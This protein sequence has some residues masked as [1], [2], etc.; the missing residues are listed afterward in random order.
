MNISKEFT[1]VTP[2]SKALALTLF[3]VLPII[4]FW[5]GISYQ[6]IIQSTKDTNP[7][8][9]SPTEEPVACTLEA[10]MCPDGT[11][12]GRIAPDCEFEQCPEIKT[13]TNTFTGTI[14]AINYQCHMDGVCSVQI[15]KGSVVLEKGESLNKQEL[16]GTFP[17]DILDETKSNAYI[18]KQVE[19]YAGTVGGRTDSYTLFGSRSYYIKLI[20]DVQT[21]CGGIAGRLCPSGYFCKYNGTYPDASGTCIKTTG[22]KTTYTCPTTEYVDCIPGPD[23]AAKTDCSSAFLKWAQSNCPN[24]KGAAY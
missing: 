19:V 7:I 14:T 23:K 13:I 5:L 11:S 21:M 15:G 3:I 2:L 1:T 16:R 18:G 12:V 22:A 4:S 24:F 8:V 9:I 20:D 17:A 10:R 6:K